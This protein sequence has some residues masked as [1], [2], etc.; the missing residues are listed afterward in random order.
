MDQRRLPLDGRATRDARAGAGAVLYVVD[1]GVF[2][3]HADFG[4]RARTADDAFA[5]NDVSPPFLR[6]TRHT[7]DTLDD[8]EDCFGHGT[9]VA[10]LAA[11]AEAGLAPAAAIVSVRVLDCDGNG[12]VGRGRRPRDGG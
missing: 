5:R 7:L 10:S 12:G 11:G 6:E 9:A 4:G 1:S 2:G 3:G 8:S